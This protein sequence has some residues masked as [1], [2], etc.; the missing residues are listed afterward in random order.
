M[1][2]ER[3]PRPLPLARRALL[4]ALAALLLLA[5]AP[6][7]PASSPHHLWLPAVATGGPRGLLGLETSALTPERDLDGL[8]AIGPGWVRRSGLR[9]R[10]VEPAPGG[11]YRWDAPALQAL[12]AELRAAAERGLR[13]VLVVQG[14]PA[15]AVAPFSADCAPISPERYGDF[16]RFIEAAVER[17][18]APP[19]NV[20][21]WEI[22]NE[23][24]AFVFAADS[25]FGC[26]GRPEQE[27]Y[28]GQAY[29]ELLKAAYPAVKRA[30][31]RAVV[32]HGGL[33]LDAP[34]NPATG[35]GR[36]G[37]FLEGVLAA[38]AGSSF[39]ILA[40][41]SYSFYDGTPDGSAGTRDWKPAYLRGILAR[42]GLSKPL[43]NTE[44]AL[45]CLE[46]GPACAE[47]QAHA[48][49]RL[50]VRALRDDLVGLIWY[51][52]DSDSFRS[53]ALIEPANP[54]LRRPAFAAFAQA[55][56]MLDGHAYGEPLAGL[57]AGVEG[58]RLTRGAG[59]TLVLWANAP[60]VVSLELDG[61][62]VPRCTSWN[63]VA[64]PCLAAG[65][66]LTLEVGPGP[67]FVL[68]GQ[69]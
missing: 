29:G 15:W 50:Y 17:Y 63:G 18:S 39:D 23:P 40:F 13:V 46:P 48:M 60:A 3:R 38:G 68:L 20:R 54:A 1:D 34:Y 9:W 7:A 35:E 61:A 65:G 53:T 10:D 36:S 52:Y 55:T 43:F 31:P 11:G 6:P 19:F 26:W 28:G 32:I 66:S 33:L 37:R 24:D 41:H 42:H 14:S 25:P 2:T 45:L 22:A 51:T 49:A 64:L 47:A 62:S 21:Y 67:I 5:P 4:V 16:A 8:R 59:S 30:D 69:G 58:H 56:A 27:L 12:D 44:G 57:P